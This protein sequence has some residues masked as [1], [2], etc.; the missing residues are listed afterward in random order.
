MS[1]GLAQYVVDHQAPGLLDEQGRPNLARVDELAKNVLMINPSVEGYLL[2]V[3][4]RVLAHALDGVQGVDPL[5]S[6]VPRPAPANRAA[7]C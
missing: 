3:K 6:A 4:G 7:P 5:G 1:L 2:S